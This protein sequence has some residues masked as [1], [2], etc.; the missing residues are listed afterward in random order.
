MNAAEISRRLDE[1]RE[2]L[3]G[4]LRRHGGICLR[5]ETPEDLLQGVH[6]KALLAAERFEY[7][8]RREFEAWSI[9]VARAHLADRAE[10][11]T[12]ARRRPERLARLTG[13]DRTSPG[14][15]AVREPAG[16]GAGPA[17][18]AE[19]SERIRRAE[20][21]LSLLLPRDAEYVRGIADGRT[22][23]E[24]AMRAGVGYAA[25]QRARLRA[26]ERFRKAFGLLGG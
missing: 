26:L 20:E 15:D 13:A 3:L 8:G 14:A 22:I 10:Y 2:R 21:A 17:T 11:W 9:R 1:D 25:A 16:E 5:F 19:R 24:D 6:V 4:F 12:A 18:R 23:E 7:R